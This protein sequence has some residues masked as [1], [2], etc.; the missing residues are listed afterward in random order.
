MNLYLR[1][2]LLSYIMIL[3]VYPLNFLHIIADYLA[4]KQ[5]KKLY[6]ISFI[7]SVL[8][9]VGSIVYA[10]YLVKIIERVLTFNIKDEGGVPNGT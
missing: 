6:Y 3:A 4:L 1:Y 7:S 10:T 9:I 2:T 8:I 5:T